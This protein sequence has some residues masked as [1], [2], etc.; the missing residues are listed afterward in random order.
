MTM[1]DD[2]R[3]KQERDDAVARKVQWL[4]NM[5]APWSTVYA[6]MK[7]DRFEPVSQWENEGG[8]GI[9]E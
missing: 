3:T 9:S 2:K 4:D 8:R 7:A 6:K 1:H 5:P